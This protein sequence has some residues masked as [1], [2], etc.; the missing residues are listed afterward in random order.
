MKNYGLR[1]FDAWAHHPY[2]SRPSE[3]PTS[4]PKAKTVVILGNIG[5]LTKEVTRL[6]GRKPIWIT[7]YGYQTR[8]PDRHFGVAWKTQAKY[9]AQSFA[10]ARKNPRIQMMIWFL[11]KDESRLAGWQS[12][13][14]TAAGK[15]KPSYFTFRAMKH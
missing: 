4:K 11:V 1:R 14:F 2:A 3:S 12:G 8:P 10:I 13:F 6:Y 7:E 9:L 15:R 5:D